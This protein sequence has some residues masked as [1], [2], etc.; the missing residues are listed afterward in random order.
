MKIKFTNRANQ[1]IVFDIETLNKL[2]EYCH[3]RKVGLSQLV[4]EA[5][6][7]KL[8]GFEY[9]ANHDVVEHDGT[10]E[11]GSQD[12][13]IQQDDLPN[14]DI[15]IVLPEPPQQAS[16]RRMFTSPQ[17]IFMGHNDEETK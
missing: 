15:A 11:I 8:A 17:E 5:V 9:D 10:S 16:I 2:K 4:R 12:L 13:D 6:K 14:P 1:T 3:S 7:E